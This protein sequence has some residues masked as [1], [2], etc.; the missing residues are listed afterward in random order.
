MVYIVKINS[1][2]IMAAE[3]SSGEGFGWDKNITSSA[4]M[5]MIKYKFVNY[6]RL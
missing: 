3:L 5:E 2:V 6:I 4:K 1:I